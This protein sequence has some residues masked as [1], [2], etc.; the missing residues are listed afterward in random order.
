[1]TPDVLKKIA[2]QGS[3]LLPRILF[4]WKNNTKAVFDRYVSIQLRRGAFWVNCARN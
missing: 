2:H 3:D 4:A 1:M